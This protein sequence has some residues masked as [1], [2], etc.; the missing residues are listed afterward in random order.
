MTRA[1]IFDIDGTLVDSNYQHALAWFRAFRQ[2]DITVPLWRLHRAIGM[3]G[4]LLVAHVTDEDTERQYG[5]RLREEQ[6]RQFDRLIEEVQPFAEAAEVLRALAQRHKVALASSGQQ[7]HID[8]CL[9]KLG[10]RD[11]VDVVV[12]S[13]DVARGK[14]D[15][16]LL[17][18]AMDK[19]G[20]QDAVMVGDSVWDGEA[21]GRAG[22]PMVATLAG[23][24]S[25]QELR[26]HGA[27]R[28]VRDLREIL[29][30]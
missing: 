22:I 15:A 6:T 29:D 13:D 16:D 4:E 8:A 27:R 2:H 28:V 11:V 3:G 5:D 23:G 1:Y 7:R 26:E 9:A 25:E 17:E 12:T 19:V 18:V 10:V 30:D 14:P 24:T 20:T 21:A